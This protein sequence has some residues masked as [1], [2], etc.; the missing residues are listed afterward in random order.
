[1]Y[2]GNYGVPTYLV[3]YAAYLLIQPLRS[4]ALVWKSAPTK[5]VRELK[6]DT[7]RENQLIVKYNQRRQF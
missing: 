7:A 2:V 6:I 3:D 4:E 1:M 5:N